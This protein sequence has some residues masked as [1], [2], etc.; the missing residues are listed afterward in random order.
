MSDW[1]DE[2]AEKIRKKMTEA[3]ERSAKSSAEAGA[4]KKRLVEGMPPLWAEMQR[5]ISTVMTRFNNGVGRQI[6]VVE[7][8]LTDLKVVTEFKGSVH[9]M[10]YSLDSSTGIV[11]GREFERSQRQSGG[12][13]EGTPTVLLGGIVDGDDTVRLTLDGKVSTPQEI[14]D[15]IARFL[16]TKIDAAAS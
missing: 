7:N 16:I 11:S 15:T 6:V 12:R 1:L 14:A 3:D 4:R 5:L 2:S 8:T 10:V 9:T 13:N